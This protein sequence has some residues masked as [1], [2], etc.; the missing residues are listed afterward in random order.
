MIFCRGVIDEYDCFPI[1]DFQKEDHLWK[2]FNKSISDL[3][4]KFQISNFK[5]VKKLLKIGPGKVVLF[6]NNYIQITN[7]LKKTVFQGLHA[8]KLKNFKF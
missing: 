5:G 8:L 3:W 2:R 7:S 4:S 6:L 1:S